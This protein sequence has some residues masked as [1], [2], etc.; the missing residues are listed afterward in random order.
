MNL[1]NVYII[2]YKCVNNNSIAIYNLFGDPTT[3]KQLVRGEK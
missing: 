1:T 2:V 3:Q